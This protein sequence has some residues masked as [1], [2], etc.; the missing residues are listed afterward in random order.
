MRLSRDSIDFGFCFVG[1]T[2]TT[3]VNLHRNG[4][5][6]YWKSVIES[7]EGD[8]RVFGVAPDFK[9]LGSKELRVTSCSHCLQISF[10]P[11]EDRGFRAVVLIQSPLLKTPLTL[12]LQGSGS[13]DEGYR[14]SSMSLKHHSRT[15]TTC[16]P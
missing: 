8:S 13:F 16:S 9:L 14:S 6:T 1:Q 15:I 12:R 10:T 11:S 5:L 3:E 4:A 2:Q 7:D